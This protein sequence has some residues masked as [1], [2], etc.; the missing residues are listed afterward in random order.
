MKF[1]QLKTSKLFYGKWPYKVECRQYDASRMHYWT[2]LLS[3]KQIDI[4][5]KTKSSSQSLINF[6]NKVKPFYDEDVQIRVEGSRFNI[7][8]KDKDLLD[9][10]CKE[11]NVWIFQ[12]TGPASDEELAYMTANGHKKRVCEKYPSEK[13]KY[14]VH[15]RQNM[16]HDTRKKFYDWL[17]KYGDQVRIIN[18]TERWLTGKSFYCQT[19]Y[20]YV[21]DSSLLSMIGM[22]LG[23]DLRSVEEFILRSSINTGSKEI[24][25]A[26]IESEPIIHSI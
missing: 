9:R 16:A 13:Y 22:F 12:V 11:L 8:L 10:I 20:F 17:T 15:L 25:N 5:I 19:P 18:S 21:N 23:N 6:Y 2:K 3:P 14:R 26:S 4:L 7:F 24:Q 1:V